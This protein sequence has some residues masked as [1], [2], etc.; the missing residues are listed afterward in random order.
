MKP[1]HTKVS[2]PG[3][4]PIVLSGI[5]IVPPR[6]Y[7]MVE[8]GYCRH[9]QGPNPDNLLPPIVMMLAGS[10]SPLVIEKDDSVMDTTPEE[11]AEHLA[12]VLETRGHAPAVA[13]IMAK[14]QV[15]GRKKKST[16]APAE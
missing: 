4:T 3:D 11:A 5:G 6:G 10:H 7:L 8:T 2:N 12:K 14:A 16:E 9:R 15:G 1:S 13:A